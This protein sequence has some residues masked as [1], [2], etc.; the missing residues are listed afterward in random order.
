MR[1][2]F[3]LIL[4]ILTFEPCQLTK[5]GMS[6]SGQ[7]RKEGILMGIKFCDMLFTIKTRRLAKNLKSNHIYSGEQAFPGDFPWMVSIQLFFEQRWLHGCGGSLLNSKWIITGN[8]INKLNT[9]I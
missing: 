4:I 3:R 1:L 2:I 8:S 7:R 9:F 6:Y 5:C